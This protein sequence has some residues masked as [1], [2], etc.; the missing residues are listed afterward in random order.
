MIGPS[1]GS[2][3]ATLTYRIEVRNPSGQTAK[4]VVVTQPTIP[5]LTLLSSN[6]QATLVAAAPSS[7]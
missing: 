3:G 7:G 5:G 2:P 6:P 4:N 1:Q